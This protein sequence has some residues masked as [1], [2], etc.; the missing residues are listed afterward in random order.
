MD[1]FLTDEFEFVALGVAPDDVDAADEL[2]AEDKVDA[3]AAAAT[4][5]DDEAADAGLDDDDAVG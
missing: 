5:D 3:D 2:F 1:L 4:D